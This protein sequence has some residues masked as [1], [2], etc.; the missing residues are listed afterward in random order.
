MGQR[1]QDN[2]APLTNI[3]RHFS[4]RNPVGCGGVDSVSA[5]QGVE[6]CAVG[7][8]HVGGRQGAKQKNENIAYESEAPYKLKPGN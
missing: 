5:H 3:A 1:H 2:A 6:K 7:R 8:V 4:P